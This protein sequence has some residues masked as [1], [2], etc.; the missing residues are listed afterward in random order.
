MSFCL[1][2]LTTTAGLRSGHRRDVVTSQPEWTLAE[3]TCPGRRKDKGS[4]GQTAE[5]PRGWREGRIGL[6]PKTALL[7]GMPFGQWHDKL[8]GLGDP[9]NAREGVRCT[10]H[11]MVCLDKENSGGLGWGWE[12]GF[13]RHGEWWM[14]VFVFNGSPRDT[15][16]GRQPCDSAAR[17]VPTWPS[18]ACIGGRR[19][20]W[21]YVQVHTWHRGIGY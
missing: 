6:G 9:G 18:V 1:D 20:G 13:P 14:F 3:P 8:D 17:Q 19:D 11:G 21:M 5:N 7:D 12:R 15:L 2:C 16:P 4:Y 10:A